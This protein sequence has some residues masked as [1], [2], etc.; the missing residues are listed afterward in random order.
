[1]LW[2]MA[3]SPPRWLCRQQ[4]CWGIDSDRQQLVCLTDIDQVLW[5]VS[6]PVLA[7]P[8]FILLQLTAAH[9]G[10]QRWWFCWHSWLSRLDYRR[11]L[12]ACGRW[13][14]N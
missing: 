4:Q 11:L 8:C 6:Q 3:I 12:R 1:M 7:T 13:R 5:R 2:Q 14:Q 10:Q 9:N